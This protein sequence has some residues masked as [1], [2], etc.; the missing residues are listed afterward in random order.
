M[1]IA[2]D[3]SIVEV[4]VLVA[5]SDGQRPIGLNVR[6]D[7]MKINLPDCKRLV[8]AYDLKPANQQIETL[9]EAIRYFLLRPEAPL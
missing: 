7:I 2:S 5:L 6:E 8:R 1:P 9:R 3:G 4:S